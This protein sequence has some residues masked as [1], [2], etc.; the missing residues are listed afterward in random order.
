MA[1]TEIKNGDRSQ[2]NCMNCLSPFPALRI[3][4]SA[5]VVA[6][7]FLRV[8]NLRKGDPARAESQSIVVKGISNPLTIYLMGKPYKQ[9][10]K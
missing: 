7:N 6:L 2:Q 3:G 9:T 4:D 1:T 8:P 10:N 5:V